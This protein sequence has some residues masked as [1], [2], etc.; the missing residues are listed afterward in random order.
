MLGLKKRWLTVRTSMLTPAVPTLPSA[1]PN[2]V[3]LDIMNY[4]CRLV[5]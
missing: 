4:G 3:M 5:R 2:P 1:D